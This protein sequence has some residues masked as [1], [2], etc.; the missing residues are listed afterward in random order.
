MILFEDGMGIFHYGLFMVHVLTC[1]LIYLQLE[2]AG[3]MIGVGKAK[4]YANVLDKP[5]SRGKQEVFP[6]DLCAH[7]LPRL[8]LEMSIFFFFLA[9]HLIALGWRSLLVPCSHIGSSNRK[10]LGV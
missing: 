6:S 9:M 1:A 7:C 2:G 3:K 4:Q 10:A 8:V 5:L